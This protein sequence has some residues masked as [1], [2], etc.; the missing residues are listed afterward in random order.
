MDPE[1]KGGRRILFWGEKEPPPPIGVNLS[2]DSGGT[3]YRNWR[4]LDRLSS[5]YSTIWDFPTPSGSH[6]VL[7][8]VYRDTDNQKRKVYLVQVRTIEAG[9]KKPSEAKKIV[10]GVDHPFYI[11]E[12]DSSRPFIA[13]SIINEH[14]LLRSDKEEGLVLTFSNELSQA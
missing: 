10:V 12:V 13:F 1:K 14:L 5:G 3:D 7:L 4:R 9:A 11:N 8:Q 6:K 2:T